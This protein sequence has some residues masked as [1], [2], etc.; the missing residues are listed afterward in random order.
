[1]TASCFRPGTARCCSIRSCTCAGI[2]GWDIETL[3]S[4]RQLGSAAAGHPEY[5][6]GKGIETTTGPLG[7][8]IAT[9]VGMALAEAMDRARFGEDLVSHR[10]FVIVGD[11][12]LM[13]GIS[14]EAISLAGH[15]RL[16]RLVVLFDDNGIT[17]DGQTALATSDD[18]RKRFEAAGWRTLSVDGHDADAIAAAIEQSRPSDRPT[19]IACRTSIGYGAPSKAGT[20]KCH[21]SPLGAAEIKGA[22]EALGWPYAPFEVPDHVRDAW[23]KA[24]GRGT[25]ARHNWEARLTAADAERRKA[26][27]DHRNRVFPEGWKAALAAHKSAVARKV[28]E[29]IKA[30]ATR[31][32]SGAALEVLTKVVPHLVGGSADLTGSVNTITKSTLPVTPTDFGGRYLHYGVREHGMAA[33]MN[34]LALHGGYVPYSGTFLVFANYLHPALRLSCLMGL[35][36]IYVL[37]HDSIGLGE[38][39][40]THQPVETLAM[41]RATPNLV[42]LRPADAVE[43]AEAW[44]IALDRKEGPTAIALSRQD[45]PALRTDAGPSNSSARGGYVLS[46]AECGVR[47]IT[48]D[49][50]GLGSLDRVRGPRPSRGRRRRRRSGVAS[51]VRALSQ[52]IGRVSGADAWAGR[53]NQDWRRSRPAFWLGRSPR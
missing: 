32:A 11:G 47:R 35:P 6:H 49:R 29:P 25:A 39:G 42:V 20:S 37:T 43:T 41:L 50:Y 18:Q 44:E 10:T 34:G 51:F 33:I 17:I 15:L 26:F 48:L 46:E 3:K 28:G 38:D 16:S 24:A 27:L 5:R 1:M 12:C 31:K 7:Q 23:T 30:T 13:E 45:L 40:P 4:F 53:R 22:R 52:S 36:V 9:A 19:M 14:Q 8:G 21:G 2:E